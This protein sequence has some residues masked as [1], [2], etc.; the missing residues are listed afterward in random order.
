MHIT[1]AVL[2]RKRLP[3]TQQILTLFEFDLN[4]CHS[5]KIYDY[6]IVLFLFTFF[7]SFADFF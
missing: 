5:Y 7:A 2:K 3:Q 4:I 1:G 6:I